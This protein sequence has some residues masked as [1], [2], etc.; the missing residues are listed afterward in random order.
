[1]LISIS[2]NVIQLPTCIIHLCI[3]NMSLCKLISI[4]N[5]N[6]IRINTARFCQNNLNVYRYVCLIPIN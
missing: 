6:V 3:T 4:I 2:A 5:V 1:M